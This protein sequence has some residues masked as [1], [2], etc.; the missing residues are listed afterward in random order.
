MRAHRLAR[1]KE[2]AAPAPAPEPATEP[3]GALSDITEEEPPSSLWGTY[4]EEANAASFRD[5]IASFRGASREAEP[6]ATAPVSRRATEPASI[7]LRHY[8][9]SD[10]MLL[11]RARAGLSVGT[12]PV[13]G[14]PLRSDHASNSQPRK[15]PLARVTKKGCYGCFKLFVEDQ[16][17]SAS[18][19]ATSRS[20]FQSG[21]RSCLTAGETGCN[22]YF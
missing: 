18:G 14:A 4:D 2:R 16:G 5:A 7:T 1:D 10:T 13:P 22:A 6:K 15:T 21:V 11:A 19:W 17:V 3:I 9:R 12:L 8:S 20:R